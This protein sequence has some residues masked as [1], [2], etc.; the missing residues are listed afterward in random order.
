VKKAAILAIIAAALCAAAYLYAGPIANRNTPAAPASG[1]ADGESKTEN[2]TWSPGPRLPNGMALASENDILALYI[3]PDTAAMAV[4]DKRTGTFWH[5]NPTDAE[6]D[7]KA[8]PLYKS[9]LMSQFTLSYLNDKG[10]TYQ[11]NSYD[12]SVIKKQFTIE[13]IDR[14]VQVTYTLGNVVKGIDVIPLMISEKR[15]KEEILDK[16]EDE[17]VRASIGYKF[18]HDQEKKVYTPRKMQDFV[19]EEVAAILESI[20]YTAEDA[21]EDN[22][23][24][25]M[26]SVSQS[27][28]IQFTVAVRYQ[29]DEDRLIVSVPT[30]ELKYPEKF[31][32]RSLHMLEFF[33][34]AGTGRDGYMFVPDGSGAIIRLN[35][36]KSNV[37]P[38]DAPVYGEDESVLIKEKVQYNEPVR[39]PVFGLVQGDQAFMAVIEEGDALASIVADVSGRN[40]SYN[41]VSARF[42][43]ISAD[44]ITLSSGSEKSSIPVFQKKMYDGELKL[45][46]S[47]LY[48]PSASYAGMAQAYRERL[49]KQY[50]WQPVS[51]DG[52]LPFVMRLD[53]AFPRKKSLLGIP[54]KSMEALTTYREVK[55][56][57]DELKDAGVR[58]IAVRYAGWFNGGIFH[59]SPR[60]IRVEPSLG[61][62]QGFADLAASLAEEGVDFY[63][64]VALMR[65]YKGASGSAYFLNKKR[66]KIYHY[67]P[68][69]YMADSSKFSHYVLS[70]S[71][72]QDTVEDFLEA[73]G[74]LGVSG[75]S[76]RDLAS[77]LNSDFN[78]NRPVDREQA[79]RL[80][81]RSIGAIAERAG[82][83]MVSGGNAYALS[84][85][86]IV[87]E[88][89]MK[90]S[91]FHILD[92]DVPFYQMVL[93]GYVEYT[94]PAWNLDGVQSIR[95]QLLKALET[96]AGVYF[97]W[98]YADPSIV[99][100][101]Q[102]DDLYSA[103]YGDWIGE[104]AK[105]YREANE[106]LRRVRGQTITGHEK[107]AEQVYRTTFENGIR[108][109]V[110]YG[111]EAAEVDGIRIDAES[112]WVGGE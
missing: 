74:K 38:Y 68:V 61:G 105:A 106:V 23:A 103:H 44:S 39:L 31:P 41:S 17:A 79:K 98:F 9:L 24:H 69:N 30:S 5:S 46:Y 3:H 77:D 1:E 15:F 58:R 108:I 11:F 82:R 93:H 87:V 49:A 107:L 33:G 112:Y 34:A 65:K 37:D 62:Q 14:G 50:D 52:E 100:N 26:E 8:S 18:A 28:S 55:K 96:G 102:Y 104:A 76:L 81:A 94:G 67:S 80:A 73:F 12:D 84:D 21:Q 110:N 57:A 88:A 97:H 83:V 99:K 70:P 85:A 86:D 19:I 53:G 64:D 63:P 59:A 71:A 92:E 109:Y 29:L 10:Q 42:N 72:L 47:F 25:G 32:I 54:Y 7:A 45:S 51:R 6:A 111:G 36:G 101:T 75:V 89:P 35:N 78:E 20:G 4:K 40:H 13:S 56:L 22:R 91:R 95:R 90:S 2:A 16:I 66:A 43:L 27:R 60:N 48:G